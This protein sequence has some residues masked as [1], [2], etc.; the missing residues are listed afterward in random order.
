MTNVPDPPI[1]DR[2]RNAMTVGKLCAE[3]AIIM[4]IIYH[5][6]AIQYTILRPYNSAIGAAI[7]PPIMKPKRYSESGKMPTTLETWYTLCTC[8]K[9]GTHD[10]VA[11]V[12]CS[13]FSQRGLRDYW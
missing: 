7:N 2:S 12:L 5:G 13:C 9:A 1:V 11:A 8:D 10:D 6:I 3:A 4:Q